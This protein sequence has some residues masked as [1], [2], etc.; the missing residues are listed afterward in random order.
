MCADVDR[1]DPELLIKEQETFELM[2]VLEEVMGNATFA[3]NDYL[4]QLAVYLDS[5]NKSKQ[6]QGDK[7]S[8]GRDW[9]SARE[10]MEEVRLALARNLARALVQ[11]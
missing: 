11:D 7:T 8:G 5:R 2:R 9:T 4:G 6:T 1:I 10:K 3:H